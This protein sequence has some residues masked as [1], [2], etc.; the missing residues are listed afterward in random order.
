L[1][2]RNNLQ[3]SA[4]TVDVA[5]RLTDGT[6]VLLPSVTVPANDVK[7][8]DLRQELTTASPQLI[9]SAGAFGSLVFRYTSLS[10]SNLYASAM[11]HLDGQPIEYHVDAFHVGGSA[12][13]GDYDGTWWAPQA[14]VN[15]FLVLGNY[16]KQQAS[17]SITLFSDTGARASTTN[18]PLGPGQ[19]ERVD[20]QAAIKQAGLTGTYG[21]LSIHCS[22]AVAIFPFQFIYDETSGFSSLMKLHRHYP[23]DKPSQ[24][25]L[26]AAMVALSNPDP[27][28]KFPAGT[29]LTARVFVRNTTNQKLPV[30]V[31]A[32]WRSPAGS[33]LAV[34]SKPVLQPQQTTLLDLS[35]MQSSSILPPDADWAGVSLQFYGRE[36][37]VAAISSSYDKSWK[38]GLQSPFTTQLAGLWMGGMWH[39]D[40]LQNSLITTGNGGTAPTLALLKIN[41]ASG[42]YYIRSKLLAPGEQ[43]WVDVGDL[44]QRQVPDAK[45]N[46]IPLAANSGTYEIQDLRDPQVGSLFEAKLTVDKTFGHA[47]YGCA[48]CCGDD[49]AWLDPDPF[50][51]GVGSGGQDDLWGLNKCYGT[52]S[53]LTGISYG[54][55][56]SNTA[57]ATMGPNKGWVNGISAGKSTITGY[58]N[59]R[60]E[61]GTGRCTFQ[62]VGGSGGGTVQQLGSFSISVISTPVTGETNSVV[63]G[64]SAQVTVKALDLAGIVMT[65]YRGTVHFSSTDSHA[66]LPSDYTF[67]A[68]DA[69]VHTFNVTLKTVVGTGPMR[70]LTVA[71]SAASVSSTQN[72]YVWWYVF[73]D[74]EFGRTVAL[75]AAPTLDL[76]IAKRR[77]SLPATAS[78]HLF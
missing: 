7:L 43:L 65:P 57:V 25:T 56:S 63:S 53:D 15:Q 58:F 50:Y 54:W 64:Q 34:L 6:E 46:V 37:D 74:V 67:T 19:T 26:R 68:T 44:K 32:N 78:R 62:P 41:F 29:S 22:N 59:A 11:I 20:L 39:A 77:I 55:T 28:L 70:D 2:L 47:A 36:G 71:D 30:N 17:A 40:N 8:V 38:Y 66:T 24:V 13:P 76:T 5:L 27:A 48:L 14:T 9:G 33:G 51:T 10:T 12:G 18:F 49:Y 16:A 4:L 52:E 69:G 35:A 23:G 42:S 1:Q 60:L 75:S 73:M 61:D 45:G 21:G 31:V 72:I 3:K